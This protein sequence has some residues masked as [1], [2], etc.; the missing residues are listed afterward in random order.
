MMRVF[1]KESFFIPLGLKNVLPGVGSV[2]N[3]M[4]ASPIF[5]P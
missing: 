3:M 1:I 2:E 4:R 5:Y